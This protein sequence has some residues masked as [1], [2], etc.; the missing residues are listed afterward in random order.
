MKLL[1]EAGYLMEEISFRTL[2]LKTDP[3]CI[4]KFEYDSLN[5]EV[6]CTYTYIDT[7][8]NKRETFISTTKTSKK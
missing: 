6:K 3:S 8:V 2:G 7:D 5:R 4:K 1:N